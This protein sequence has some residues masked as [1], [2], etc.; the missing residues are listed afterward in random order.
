[1]PT[2]KCMNITLPAPIQPLLNDYVHLLEKELPGFVTGLY[3]HGSIALGAFNIHLSDIDF[4]AFITRHPTTRDLASLRAIHQ[5][6]TTNHPRW[7]LEGSYLQWGDLGKL[8][9]TIAPFPFYHD[10]QFE[11]AGKFDVNSVTWWVL[12]HR[13]IALIGPES[14]T[15]PLE[16][17][18][19]LLVTRMQ[20][21]LN[22]YW[23]S[24]TRDPKRIAWFFTDFGIE[25][26]VLGVLRQYYTFIE[27]DIT[28]KTGA[29]EYALAHL[30]IKWHRLI[31][32]A[33]RIRKQANTSHDQSF[34]KSR[35]AR[36]LE[37]HT[38]LRYIIDSCNSLSK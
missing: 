30:P 22:S 5:T 34:Y 24:F 23:M 16:V 2:K 4:I 1:M 17:D 7:A 35:G 11:E 10:T 3:L 21:N 29:G 19:D 12:K 38:F 28:S 37:A 6:I 36:A 20:E 32:E 8:E 27:Q 14:H 26:T 9:N 15:L 25:W 33:I 31:R 13:G 18:W